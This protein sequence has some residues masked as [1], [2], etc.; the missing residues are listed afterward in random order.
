MRGME[1]IGVL[2]VGLA[3]SYPVI[4]QTH[5]IRRA[6]E[7]MTIDG[8]LLE[9]DWARADV[10]SI[11]SE[12]R[13]EGFEPPQL[14]TEVR[15][16]WDDNFLYL[17][18]IVYEPHIVATLKKRDDIIYH[19]NDFEIFI[20]TDRDGKRYFEVEV[21]AYNTVMD[22]Y[23]DKPYKEGGNALLTYD[24]PLESAVKIAGSVND[25]SDIDEYWAVEM[26]IPKSHVVD[27]GES[28]VIR[29]GETWLMNFS[30]VQWQFEW[31]DFQYVKVLEDPQGNKIREKNGV[32]YPTGKIDIHIPDKW[33]TVKF[34][35][36]E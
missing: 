2:V 28:P 24:V 12:I 23:M 21:N 36:N 26:K 19:D 14:K 8:E 22:L 17:F 25:G 11:Q 33:G 20:D 7:P 34:V 31:R 35:T 15:M 5:D 29:D 10:I 32:W 4:S 16:L 13:G 30:R 27:N 9:A 18:A 1:V 6:N 3:V